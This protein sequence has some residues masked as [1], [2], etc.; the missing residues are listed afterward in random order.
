MNE[1]YISGARI[2]FKNNSGNAEE[3]YKL[4]QEI[5]FQN[6]IEFYF[7]GEAILRN[8]DG[9]DIDVCEEV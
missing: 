1:L 5:C 2:Y 3:A 4:L 7:D 8:E 6:D 9:E